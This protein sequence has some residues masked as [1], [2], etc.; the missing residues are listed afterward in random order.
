ML[1]FR[2]QYLKRPIYFI[3]H[4][5]SGILLKHALYLA[6]QELPA[7]RNA[8]AGLIF[9]GSPHLTSVTDQR[10]EFWKMILKMY[11][12]DLPK[13]ILRTKD[14]KTLAEVCGKFSGLNINTPVLS[15]YEMAESKMRD[16]GPLERFRP[17]EKVVS[18][19]HLRRK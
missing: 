14:I 13:D 11:R 19:V 6:H 18:C 9:L 2:V 12:K 16:S 4:S 10:W 5:L 3:C 7:I 15:V 1:S 8:I 17:L